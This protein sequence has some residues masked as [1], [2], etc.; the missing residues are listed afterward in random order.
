MYHSNIA[1]T[2]GCWCQLTRHGYQSQ[3]LIDNKYY[4][5]SLYNINTSIIKLFVN[6]CITVDSQFCDIIQENPNTT[7][8]ATINDWGT[9]IGPSYDAKHGAYSITL[10]TVYPSFPTCTMG[11]G[12]ISRYRT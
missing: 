7:L 9:D 11:C 12:H 1:L 2:G 10:R 6:V 5:Y 3:C 4:N 8:L